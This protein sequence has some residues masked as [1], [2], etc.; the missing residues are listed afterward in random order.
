MSARSSL[1]VALALLVFGA[2]TEGRSS[3]DEQVPAPELGRS[4]GSPEPPPPP[5]PKRDD[6]RPSEGGATLDRPADVR[7]PLRELDY[8]T[9]GC[10]GRCP[11]Q[12]LVLRP[13]GEFL[14]IGERHTKRA[15]V[16][17][18]RA[19]E[20]LTAR[21][22]AAAGEPPFDRGAEY[23]SE[24]SDQSATTIGSVD[25][26]D[27]VVV[28]DYG[29]VAPEA[30]K[31]V[32]QDFEEL[33]AAIPNASPSERPKEID[34]DHF[35]QSSPSP[36]CRRYGDA[37]R[38]RCVALGEG[39][40]AT[41]GCVYHGAIAAELDDLRYTFD[42]EA[43][44][45]GCAFAL[46]SVEADRAGLDEADPRAV[47]HLDAEMKAKCAEFLAIVFREQGDPDYPDEVSPNRGGLC[48]SILGT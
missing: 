11:V 37:I 24:F 47:K 23:A 2:C 35:V 17:V 14:Y 10:Y 48:E 45:A 8:R 29:F 36:S 18:G 32:E 3:V 41:R 9:S 5:P 15:G 28:S 25:G 39:R 40:T 46:D 42:G 1:A 22:F 30:V 26:R 6:P 27:R 7:G 33:I 44:E 31:A 12:R 20:E 13:S 21:L 43:L 16:Y 4:P 34:F 38:E 19:D